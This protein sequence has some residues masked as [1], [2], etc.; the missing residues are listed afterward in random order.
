VTQLWVLE[1]RHVI[2]F[3]L[4]DSV[5]PKGIPGRLSKVCGE[6]AVKKT[7]VFYWVKKIRR[8]RKDL[9]GEQRPGIGL[10]MHLP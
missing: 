5:A 3:L 9:G 7:Q 6:E 2:R 1:Q 4:K 8:W 10:D